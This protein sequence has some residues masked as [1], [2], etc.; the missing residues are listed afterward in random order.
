MN[1]N[2]KILNSSGS[3][4]KISAHAYPANM[5][6]GLKV[7][8][9]SIKPYLTT[10]LLVLLGSPLLT[11]AAD[12]NEEIIKVKK[13]TFVNLV[14]LL[15]KRGV[16]NQ[17]EAGG[18][19]S[20]AE[21]ESAAVAAESK[22]LPA[23]NNTATTNSAPAVAETNSVN[24]ADK[25]A[26]KT[27]HV[28]Y[29][30]EFVKN[31]L[32]DQLRA[33]L[34]AE[35]VNDVKQDAKN[36]GWG[37]PAA[38]PDWVAALHPS[39]DMRLRFQDNFFG[40]TN[41]NSVS[42]LFP[43]PINYL[44]VNSSYTSGQTSGFSGATAQSPTSSRYAFN[45]NTKDQLL[46]RERFRLGFETDIVDGLKAGV[47]LATSNTYSPVSNDQSLGNTGQSYQF[48]IDRSYLQY[49]YLD[50][51]KT[52]W[53][54]A[55][56]GR[57]INPFLSTD[58]VFDPDLSFEGFATSFRFHM[59][60]NNARVSGYKAAS[61]TGRVGINQGQQT[62]DSLFMTLGV[63]PI[64]NVN[65][66]STSKWLY[67][68]Q[69]GADWL[70][71]DDSRFNVGV[72]YYEYQNI[73]AQYNGANGSGHQYDW[74]APQFLQ[75]GNSMV[76]ITNSNTANNVCLDATGCLFGLA[77]Q[78]RI[79]NATAVYDYLFYGQTHVL[80]TA[81]Y[82]RNLGYNQQEI[83][84]QFVSGIV[85]YANSN[86]RTTAYQMRLDVG[87]PRVLRR[88]DWNMSFAYRYLQRDSVLDAFTDSIFHNGGTNAKGWVLAAQ[89][90]LAKNTWMDVHWYSTQTV[91]G[92]TYNVDTIN[93]DLNTRF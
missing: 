46:L 50:D 80:L 51:K 60:Q 58:L 64:Q 32:R 24:G 8:K 38:L 17:D 68:G 20:N 90:G 16:I 81:D 49:D 42:N 12:Q 10:F 40:S 1:I 62:P 15:V 82:A 48:A 30:P 76:A 29:V 2:K 79:F 23:T 6:Q 91:D 26:P 37:I 28:G 67:A 72:A 75:Q 89:Y 47:R 4:R 3:Y 74:T 66:S 77:S 56:G 34:K 39:M 87:H 5:S 83:N 31:E 65:F 85:N 92:P 36:E 25:N 27:K 59:N 33:E 41:S 84:R 22:A 93:F 57:I 44:N 43:G 54:S 71:F 11:Q 69:L 14:D 19:V 63:F 21:Q 35:V 61:P 78:F 53:F 86:P 18:L 70:V 88:S 73:T 7:G 13:S 52:S 45:N 9:T 55:Y